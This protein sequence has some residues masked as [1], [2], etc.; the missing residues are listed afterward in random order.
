MM[1]RKFRFFL[2]WLAVLLCTGLLSPRPSAAQAPHSFASGIAVCP[3]APQPVE[4]VNPLVISDCTRAGIQAALNQGGHIRFNCGA[5]PVTIPID[6]TLNLSTTKDTVLDGGGLVTLDGQNAVRIL[7]KDWHDPNTVGTVGVT[8]QN[9]RLIRGR[10]PAGGST[11]DHSGGAIRA[12]HPGTRLHILNTTFEDNATRSTGIE[13]NQGGA[14]FAHNAYELVISGSVFSGNTAGNG[15]AIGIIAV[16]LEI[17][18]SRFEA[19]QAVDG[20]GGGIVRGYGGAMH[21]DGVSNS[22]NPNSSNR[23]RVCGSEFSDNTAYRGGGAIGA[24]VSDNLGTLA[25]YEKSTFYRNRVFGVSGQNGQGG[26]IY[27][28][29]DDHA[30]GIQETNLIVREVTFEENQAQRQGGALWVYILGRGQVVN[31]TF[32]HNRTTAGYNQMGQ[33]GAMAVTLGTIGITNSVFAYNHADYQGGALHGGGDNQ[34][35]TLTN[36]IFLH[37][38]LNEQDLPSETRWQGYHTNRSMLD[39]GK[40]IQHPR[41][42][43]TYNNEVNN[44]ITANPIF[45]DPLLQPLADNGGPTRTM[46][47]SSGSPA[48]NQGVQSACPGLD[49][50][51]YVRQ[52]VCDIGP[53]E[54]GGQPFVASDFVF[55][56]VVRR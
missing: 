22:Y 5:G 50:R 36:T 46:A 38:T 4:L 18:N 24:V 41:F 23:L 34:V 25:V 12:G 33:G 45:L 43:P 30:G 53:F 14:I 39:G 9:L 1:L 16:G 21:V 11:G 37:N 56:P 48:V 6:Q 52:G 28:I 10:A 32:A 13:D 49:Q 54:Y 3:G 15:G 19:N 44:R 27:H 17:Y 8:L 42:K 51:G 2:C 20:S 7:S 35:I 47:L 40:N 26:A 29:E 55:L 31:T